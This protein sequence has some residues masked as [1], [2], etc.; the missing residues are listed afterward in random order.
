M[1]NRKPGNDN[2]TLGNSLLGYFSESPFNSERTLFKAISYCSLN[3]LEDSSSLLPF[4][5][6]PQK[7][8][9]SDWVTRVQYF[10][11]CTP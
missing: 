4:I 5:A 9:H 3:I 7:Y 6:S 10:S 8:L 11:N 2:R 1:V